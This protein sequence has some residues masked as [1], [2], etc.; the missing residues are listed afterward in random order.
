M[1]GKDLLNSGKEWELGELP[2]GD[3]ARPN[4]FEAEVVAILE[5]LGGLLDGGLLQVVGERSLAGTRSGAGQDVA[6]SVKNAEC[7][8]RNAEWVKQRNNT[9]GVDDSRGRA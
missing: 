5:P 7:G 3:A 2:V 6:A 8:V 4:N 9:E 1:A